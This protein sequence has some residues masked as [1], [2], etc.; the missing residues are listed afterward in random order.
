MSATVNSFSFL[1][2]GPR[3][4]LP[5][6]VI[7]PLHF[8]LNRKYIFCVRLSSPRIWS[9]ILLLN[10]HI[11][12]I[13]IFVC[14]SQCLRTISLIKLLSTPSPVR[15]LKAS[16]PGTG[17]SMKLCNEKAASVFPLRAFFW[18]QI[19]DFVTRIKQELLIL[20]KL[21]AKSL[22]KII[23]LLNH[24]KYVRFLCPLESTSEQRL[25]FW[26][27]VKFWKHDFS[28]PCEHFYDEQ[29]LL[30]WHLKWFCYCLIQL[31]VDKVMI[32]QM[33]WMRGFF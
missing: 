7:F 1:Y 22:F 30:Y 14:K 10:I 27:C 21:K 18:C 3:L 15:T 24:F 16:F 13:S 20:W 26:H 32:Y 33:F 19:N 4:D 28:F 5:E 9:H 23:H 31:F 29:I 12:N 17:S 11:H 6:F 8:F 2:N 25:S